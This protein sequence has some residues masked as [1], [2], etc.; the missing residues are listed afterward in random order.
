VIASLPMYDLPDCRAANDR[1]WAGIR[2]A[3]RKA[4]IQAPDTLSRGMPDFM[5]H[6]QRPD[7]V[8]S[9]TCGFPFRAVLQGRVTLIGTPDFGLEGCPPGYYQSV[10]VVRG[11]DARDGV[12]AFKDARF[13]YNEALS[14]SGWA[15]PQTHAAGLGFRFTP[16][17]HTGGHALSALAVLEGR[18]DIA[19]IDAATWRLLQRNDA[20][21]AG[22]RVVGRTEPTPCLP[23]IAALGAKHRLVFDAVAAA[24]AGLDA[25]DRDT[26]GIKRIL[27]IPA[28]AYLAVPTPA[29]PMP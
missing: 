8:L 2:D 11:D 12:M 7:L 16:A 19:A 13:A 6:W 21:M 26:L 22:L 29:P 14:Q 25:V 3:L 27:F 15:A 24:I 23:Y 17:V 1:Y 4:G 9:Q 10:F 5:A 28:V 18:A 20:A